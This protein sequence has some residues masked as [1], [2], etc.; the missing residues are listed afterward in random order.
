MSTWDDLQAAHTLAG[1]QI[2]EGRDPDQAA[3]EAIWQHCRRAL[4][5]GGDGHPHQPRPTA[6]W[7]ARV[8]ACPR[9]GEQ[10]ITHRE[11]AGYGQTVWRW[12][13]LRKARA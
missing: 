3:L 10:F 8:W 4:C 7:R 13:L 1:Q 6:R 12:I 2:H 5:A 9:C 11:Y